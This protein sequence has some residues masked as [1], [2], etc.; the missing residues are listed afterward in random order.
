MP[1]NVNGYPAGPI[2]FPDLT[3][4][5]GPLRPR[6]TTNP[7]LSASALLYLHNQPPG[8][9]IDAFT[10][11]EG[12]TAYKKLIKHYAT[13]M[14]S[15]V[16]KEHS[17]LPRSAPC[18]SGA[19][20]RSF[21]V[22]WNP[23]RR[24]SLNRIAGGGQTIYSR[25]SGTPTEKKITP[26]KKL[27]VL[28]RSKAGGAVDLDAR[29]P[30][31]EVYVCPE[32]TCQQNFH[33]ESTRG[34]VI[35]H[36]R[37]DTHTTFLY[38]K[39]ANVCP[40]WCHKGFHDYDLLKEHI[41]ERQ[42]VF[43]EKGGN[44]LFDI[45]E[46][47]EVLDSDQ[48]LS[49]TSEFACYPCTILPRNMIV[50]IEIAI[51]LELSLDSSLVWRSLCL[52]IVRTLLQSFAGGGRTLQALTH[53]GGITTKEPKSNGTYVARADI[54][55]EDGGLRDSPYIHAIFSSLMYIAHNAEAD[56]HSE[57]I[58]SAW[59]QF[60]AGKRAEVNM[61]SSYSQ[62]HGSKRKCKSTSGK[63]KVTGVKEYSDDDDAEIE[64]PEELED[65]G[66]F[67]DDAGIE[68]LE[69]MEGMEND[70]DN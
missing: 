31:K 64:N 65:M 9:F 47:V 23:D 11:E 46:T 61:E 28:P 66:D 53:G 67:I 21:R 25:I 58:L 37:Y 7:H 63:A 33:P 57:P 50:S 70:K 54:C 38:R 49:D 62:N 36:L 52:L 10:S 45:Q 32:P 26:T 29:A 1:V 59:R 40:F 24:V 69:E 35:N 51:Y 48:K 6:Y 13:Y 14:H 22:P 2:P 8:N 42:Y 56:V 30:K 19:S 18:K 68:G 39:G 12:L 17:L 44:L 5:S 55:K 41:R 4:L 20:A 27:Q 15:R 60:A 43:E 3:T 34:D 16:G